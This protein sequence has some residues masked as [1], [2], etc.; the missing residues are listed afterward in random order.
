[1]AIAKVALL[2]MFIPNPNA[3]YWQPGHQNKT[4]ILHNRTNCMGLFIIQALKIDKILK[5][6]N[7]CKKVLVPCQVRKHDHQ[8]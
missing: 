7:K 1:M 5:K 2:R 8:E 6:A 4:L 3:F